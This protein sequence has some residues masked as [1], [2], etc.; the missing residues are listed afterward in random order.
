MRKNIRTD[1]FLLGLG[2]LNSSGFPTSVG[3][4]FLLSWRLS[5]HKA[6][7]SVKLGDSEMKESAG[8]EASFAWLSFPIS[9]DACPS[10]FD[11]IKHLFMFSTLCKLIEDEDFI[12][13]KPS[14]DLI[15]VVAARP[16]GIAF[17]MLFKCNPIPDG[18]E[19]VTGKFPLHR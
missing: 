15:P 8:I 13:C 16:G 7:G 3:L 9:I 11:E 19:H 17:T 6:I 5:G 4:S 1:F 12:P 2:S 14:D 18:L 10:I